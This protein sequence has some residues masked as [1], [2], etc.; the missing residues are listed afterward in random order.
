MKGDYTSAVD[1]L[2]DKAKVASEDENT[3]RM[4]EAFNDLGVIYKENLG[5]IGHAIDAHEAAQTLEPENQERNELLAALY[6]TNPQ[7]YFEKAVGAQMA[8]LR[9]NP[10]RESSYKLLR[11]LYTDSKRA[12]PAWCLCQALYVLKL[13]EPDEERFFRRMRSED[14]AYAQDVLNEE[15]WLTHLLHEDAD[16]L[17]TSVFALIEPA[18]IA[19]RSQ[20]LSELGYDARYAIDPEQHPYPVSQTLH[21]AAGV[22]GMELPP[23]FENTNDAG[24]LSFLHAETPALVLGHAALT[25]DVPPQ[26]AAFIAGRHLAYYRPGLY[27]R[28]LVPNAHGLKSWLFA[29]I[30]MN[31]PQF[32]VA[33]DMQGPVREATAALETKLSAQVRDHLARIVSKLLQ[34]GRALDLKKWVQGIDLTADRAGFLLSHDLETA[35]EIIRASDESASS[36]PEQTRLKELVLFAINEHYFKLRQRLHVTIDA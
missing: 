14:P 20:S 11:K 13:A 18:I 1:H 12:D 16:T 22:M 25:A 31:A 17:L 23:T 24:G 8:M 6:A 3:A 28:Y 19:T 7:V 9:Q 5:R 15:D 4:L 2:K 36:A 35:V 29:A 21:Y 26:A 34:S 10:F 27:M 30:K 33:V 32:P